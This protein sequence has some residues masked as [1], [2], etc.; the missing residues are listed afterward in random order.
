VYATT[1][2]YREAVARSHRIAIRVQLLSSIQ[3]GPTPEGGLELPILSG[4]IQLSSTSDIKG[5]LDVT[6]PGDYWGSVQPYGAEIFAERGVS[7][8]DGT[9]E[10][11]PL[12]YYRIEDAEQ[13]GNA[14]WG[15]VKVKGTDRT[16]QMIDARLPY[17]YNYPDGTTHTDLFNRLINGYTD[18][19][20]SPTGTSWLVSY[21]MYHTATV[22]I[23]FVG[24]NG[25]TATLPA[26]VV[27]D[28]IYEH[29]AK[30]ADARGCVLRFDRLGE[31]RIEPRDRAP[32]TASV[33]TIAPGTSGNLISATRRV[34]RAGVYNLVVA[35][36]SDPQQPTG[37]RLAYNTNPTSPIRWDGPFGAV[38]RYYASPLLRTSEQADLAA[39]TVLARYKGL[40]TG[41]AVVTVPDPSIDPLDPISVQ[42]GTELQEHLADTVTIP[43]TVDA[44]VTIETRTLNEIPSSEEEGPGTG[45]VGNPTPGTG[46]GGTPGTGT[47]GTGAPVFAAKFRDGRAFP[48]IVEP[49]SGQTVVNVS[50]TSALNSALASAGPGTTIVAADGTYTGAITCSRSG[51]ATQP[52][53]IKSQNLS[54]AKLGSGA[55]LRLTGTYI[56]LTGWAK[57]LD[58]S[59]KSFSIE[60]GKFCRITRCRVGPASL[61]SPDATAAKSLHFY[62]GGTAE[63]CVID[64]NETRFKSKP[65]NGILVDGN[66]DGGTTG[67]AKHILIA[68]ND[69]HDYGTEAV[70]DFEAIRF[71]VSS[72]QET[73]SNSAIIRNVFTNIATEPEIISVKMDTVDVWG[74]T[75]RNCIGSLSSRHG[76][77]NRFS[78]NYVVGPATGTLGTKAGGQ[79]L[80]DDDIWVTDNYFEAL[81]GSGFQDTICIDGGD[82]T[83]GG[84]NN[85]HKQVKRARV[86]RNVIVNSASVIT[87][88]R[89][90]SIAPADLTITDNV[91]V[92][93]GAAPTGGGTGGGTGTGGGIVLGG[94]TFFSEDFAAGNF[95]N[96]GAIQNNPSGGEDDTPETYDQS[97]YHLKVTNQSAGRGNVARFEIRNGDT[98]GGGTVERNE[99]VLPSSCDVSEGAERW[100]QF[101]VRLG[102][103][104]W[105]NPTDWELIWQW[106]H[107]GGTGS[108]PLSLETHSSGTVKLYQD[109]LS[110][111]PTPLTLWTIRPGEWERVVMNVKFSNDP[112]IGF[113]RVWVNN[114]EVMP[115]TF[116]RTMID[117][118]NYVKCG[119]YR[120][121]DHTSTQVLM[122]GNLKVTSSATLS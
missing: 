113:I 7:F 71:G 42:I 40:P 10:Y 49:T 25:D 31:L 51:S 21:G 111:P 9:E 117:S 12:G 43:L 106:H 50:T 63:D 88:G 82:T 78:H 46:G 14:P 23:R 68:H 4:D 38:P 36:G 99:L 74:N 5:T 39:E 34:A 45:G 122:Y 3:F 13:S 18:P 57:D 47:P 89:N 98:A 66:F 118:S 70:N 58:D 116:R 107:A 30:V 119:I 81:N 112:A 64:Y 61:G 86:Q 67:G 48:R 28:S 93:S 84:T 54:G 6:V 35:R 60:S 2:R 115:K 62:I 22:P 101:D 27:E 96:F 73:V 76:A 102:D 55:S 69:L 87:V 80:Y 90:Y 91:V 16:A 19:V 104:T 110:S 92:N 53:V 75:A 83:T 114:V 108:P 94:T 121:G 59:G 11:V 24:Y 109:G 97:T 65:G 15:P 95:A 17:P 105:V 1:S 41:L 120:S 52:I 100:Y 85:G 29:L 77:Q 44:P 37:Y 26:G 8:G 72:M 33:Y 56:L 32:G 20:G 79:R 103:P